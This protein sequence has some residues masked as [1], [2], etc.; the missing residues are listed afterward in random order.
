MLAFFVV[1]KTALGQW[2]KERF[3]H[4]KRSYG[5]R[6]GHL[7][8]RPLAVLRTLSSG[9]LGELGA[10]QGWPTGLSCSPGLPRP[11]LFL[12]GLAT[13]VSFVSSWWA[14]AGWCSRIEAESW[15][16]CSS[17]WVSTRL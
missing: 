9:R 2:R 6:L 16:G 12:P 14:R 17:V 10:G 4:E 13:F 5:R 3:F 15:G 11:L 1:L 8:S 7:W